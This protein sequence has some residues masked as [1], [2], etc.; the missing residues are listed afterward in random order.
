MPTPSRFVSLAL[1]SSALLFIACVA[2]PD[3]VARLSADHAL[4]ERSQHGLVEATVALDDAEIT[5]GTNDL[6]ISL[7]GS[8]STATP[9]LKSVDAF[10]AAHGHRTSAESIAFDGETFHAL[11]LDLFMSG[12]WQV[13]LGVELDTSSDVVEFALDVP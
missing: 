6:S 12:R 5:R 9:L 1:L 8:P 10:M 2:T 3:D 13:Q 7:R 4:V 11:D